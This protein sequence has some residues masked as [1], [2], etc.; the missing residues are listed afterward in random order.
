MEK[1]SNKSGV[2]EDGDIEHRCHTA[3]FLAILIE[4]VK[5]HSGKNAAVWG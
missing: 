5:R 4:V 2:A 1:T 3:G